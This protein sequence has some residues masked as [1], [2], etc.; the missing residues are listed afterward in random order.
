MA[1]CG[2]RAKSGSRGR[3]G[4]GSKGSIGP[5][6]EIAKAEVEK[7]ARADVRGPFLKGRLKSVD[8]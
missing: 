4:R 2:S 5:L 6:A 3:N 8:H 7:A 1:K